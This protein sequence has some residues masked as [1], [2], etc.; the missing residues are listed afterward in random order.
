MLHLHSGPAARAEVS[1]R[2]GGQ[3]GAALRLMR[4]VGARGAVWWPKQS[5][6]CFGSAESPLAC[7]FARPLQERGAVAR[8]VSAV[9][10]WQG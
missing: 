7:H 5:L 6:F 4:A 8:S 10:T 2:L 3:M 1:W 9:N